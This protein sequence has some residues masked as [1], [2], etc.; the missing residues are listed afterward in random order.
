MYITLLK[1]FYYI[2]ILN[3]YIKAHCHFIFMVEFCSTKCT[4]LFFLLF[5]SSNFFPYVEPPRR[6]PGVAAARVM[7]LYHANGSR[8]SVLELRDEDRDFQLNNLSLPR[9][10]T[11]SFISYPHA[12]H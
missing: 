5:C 9:S 1:V 2:I 12:H 8:F 7:H 3:T 4:T 6:H 10:N 11:P